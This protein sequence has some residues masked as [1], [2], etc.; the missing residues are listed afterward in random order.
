MAEPT[1][2]AMAKA[3]RIL[4]FELVCLLGVILEVID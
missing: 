3:A 2:A 1:R 4:M